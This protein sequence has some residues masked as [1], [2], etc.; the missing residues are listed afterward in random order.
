MNTKT[1]SENKRPIFGQ[2]NNAL[3]WLI[4]LNLIFFI[5]VL[6]LKFVYILS[7]VKGVGEGLYLLN[8]IP[9]FVIPSDGSLILTKAWTIITHM[10]T[11]IEVLGVL[12]QMMWLYAFGYIL[13]DLAGNKKLF[14]IYLY[15][16]LAGAL[17][18]ISSLFIFNTVPQSY[19]GSNAAVLAIAAATITLAPQY[20]FL[21]Q[22]NGGFPIWILGAIFILLDISTHIYSTPHLLAHIAG[23]L[24]GFLFIKLLQ[25]GTDAGAWINNAYDFLNNLFSPDK[26]AN[27]QQ[28]YKQN[29]APFIKKPNATQQRLDMVLD[30]INKSGITSLSKEEKEFL[31][32]ASK[33]NLL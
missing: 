31:E 16:G 6:F 19:T 23:A 14:P 30:K 15:G 13:Q 33:E 24:S 2:D 9:Q 21:R 3:T 25:G 17:V 4:I 7:S 18:Y 26:N 29:M 8:I 28:Y 1:Y 5:S 22:L 10:F 27:K 32:K 12:S 20:R 11:N